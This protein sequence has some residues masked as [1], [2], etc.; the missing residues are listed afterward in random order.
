VTS[1]HQLPGW[2]AFAEIIE[3]GSPIWM[4]RMIG[5]VSIYHQPRLIKKGGVVIIKCI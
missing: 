5:A 1:A 4:I 3:P 2:P